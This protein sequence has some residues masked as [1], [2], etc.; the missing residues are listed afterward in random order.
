L[1][2]VFLIAA[3]INLTFSILPTLELYVFLIL[4]FCQLAAMAHSMDSAVQKEI[5]SMP[6][7]KVRY[8]NQHTHSALCHSLQQ[9]QQLTPKIDETDILIHPEI[10][11]SYP[12]L[13]CS[14][15]ACDRCALTAECRTHSGPLSPTAACSA[16]T[17]AGSTEAWACMSHL[18][19]LSLWTAGLTSRSV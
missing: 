1:L 3:Y 18:C 15:C 5:R 16:W 10:I 14:Y 11:C 6:G 7:N 9:S 2:Q 12:P 8:I 17:A 13:H 19:A 4:P